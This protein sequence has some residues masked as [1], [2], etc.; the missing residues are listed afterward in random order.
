MEPD[1]VKKKVLKGGKAVAHGA[2]R[3]GAAA[4][5]AATVGTA[6]AAAAVVSGEKAGSILATGGTMMVAGAQGL[7]KK[8][9]G[10]MDNVNN[11]IM[12]DYN[13]GRYTKDELKKIKR[14]KYDREWK[15]KEENYKY[16][17]QKRNMS[18]KEAKE[19][20]QDSQTQKYLDQG[21]TDIGVICNARDMASKRGWSDDQA[22]SRA[23][24]AQQRGK[25]LKD[26]DTAQNALIDRIMNENSA[27]TR[28][29]ARSLVTEITNIADV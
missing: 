21:I 25:N 6:T 10:K 28:D 2:V 9:V 11:Q 4:A 24:L 17:M 22:L 7:G 23:K 16:L 13:A 19:Y 8:A 5:M 27:I 12:D 26:N 20:L 18:S 29:M 3:A 15:R 14:D 1:N